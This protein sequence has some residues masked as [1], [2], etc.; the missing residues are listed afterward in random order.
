[1]TREEWLQWR[2]KG[3]GGSDAPVIVNASEH[4]TPLQ[5]YDEK[6]S[7]DITE[8]DNFIQRR[9]NEIEPRVR[10][11]FEMKMVKGYPAKLLVMDGFEFIRASLDGMS[12]DGEVIEIKLLGKE[13]YELAKS[14]K[15]PDKHWP[16][17]QHNLMVSN[18]VVCFYLGYPYEKTQ[19]KVLELEKLAIV[20][21]PPDK[22]YME[23]LL[24]EEMKFWDAVT[25]KKPPLPS[26]RDFKKLRG[27][28][29]LPERF[30]RAKE[31]L[32]NASEDFEQ[33]KAELISAAGATGHP[34]VMAG[35]VRLLQISRAGNVDY[36]SV[37]ELKGVDLEKY[38][39]AGSLYWKVE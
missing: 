13:D 32:A 20:A 1:M 23:W 11:L 9:G 36:S 39:K 21:A 38:R 35:D 6:L 19:P 31:R 2:K 27:I 10:S 18:G 29:T 3:I 37:P 7:A 24:C 16:Q 12:E 34:R 15:V 22:R 4:R 5:L 28:G 17:V 26:D 33:L 8:E 14:G 30:R 25:K